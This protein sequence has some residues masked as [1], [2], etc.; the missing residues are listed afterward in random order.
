MCDPN[1]LFWILTP[2]GDLY[3]E[4]LQVPLAT[5]I[6]WLNERNELIPT[7]MMLAGRRL[8]Q[9]YKFSA[10]RRILLSTEVIVRAVLGAQ[11]TEDTCREG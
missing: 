11:E 6:L 7:T 1:S 3:P 5:G 8:E 10:H 4:L 2:D 9:G